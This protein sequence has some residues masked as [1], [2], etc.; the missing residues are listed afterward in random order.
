MVT[1]R[2]WSVPPSKHSR[3]YGTTWYHAS[4]VVLNAVYSYQVRDTYDVQSTLVCEYI[5]TRRIDDHST[6]RSAWSCF[7]GTL[8]RV[9]TVE[10]T[11]LGTG[12]VLNSACCCIAYELLCTVVYTRR[13]RHTFWHY[14]K[15]VHSYIRGIN[16][17]S[18]SI[19]CLSKQQ[20]HAL[21]GLQQL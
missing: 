8:V 6:F 1:Q 4:A 3:K 16:R 19:S 13:K 21:T 10:S 20:T 9:L 15:L 12:V 11:S 7:L 18:N 5:Y 14:P 17:N 2:C